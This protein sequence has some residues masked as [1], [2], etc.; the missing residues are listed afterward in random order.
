[1]TM[2]SLEPVAGSALNITPEAAGCTMR[3]TTTAI[4]G[5]SVMRRVAR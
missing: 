3:W 4:A 5:S 2:V 1:M